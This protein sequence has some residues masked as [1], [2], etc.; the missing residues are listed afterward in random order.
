MSAVTEMVTAPGP[1][2]GKHI[3][4]PLGG[5]L[6]T[7]GYVEDEWFVSGAAQS[8]EADLPRPPDGRW[9]ARPSAAAPFRTR[10][11]VR[12][13]LDPA[14]FNG[15]VLVEWLNVSGGLDSD[16]E[17][18]VMHRHITREGFAWVGV[19]A[20]K[21]GI[22]GGGGFFDGLGLKQLDPLRYRT[23][24]HPGDAFSYDIFTQVGRAVRAGLVLAPL[25]PE[26][27]LALGESQS[28]AFLV[29]YI[30]GI[31]HSAQ[32]FDGYLVH[33][34][35][36][37]GAG[38]TGFGIPIGASEEA[39]AAARREVDS[40]PEIIRCDARTPVL[41][42]QSETDV[43]TL[44]S[45]ASRQEDGPH[46]RLWE[47]AGAA[48]ADTY[49][50]LA[51]F[52]NNG[53]LSPARLAELLTPIREVHGTS[54]ERPMNSGPQQHYVAHAA[55][56]AL[57]AWVRDGQPP[58]SAPR[59]EVAESGGGFVLDPHG[60]ARGGLRTPWVDVPVAKLSGVPQRE[61]HGMAFLLGSTEAFTRGQLDS[62]YPGGVATYLE[63]FRL[64]LT[65]CVAA[66][67]LLEADVAEIEG[68]AAANYEL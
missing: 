67:F 49:T 9:A 8:Y 17:W 47:I 58:P 7:A 68:V 18:G 15:T 56:S 46:M 5:D 26:R 61:G 41:V 31:D 13:P 53:L 39:V 59:L 30:N 44:G 20:Q 48:H 52:Q 11:L 6:T 28:A 23:L 63:R 42:M 10:I 37:A 64:A 34:R 21:I 51:S 2:P 45:V 36:A 14:R 35:G 66:G 32:V 19:S 12:R 40:H 29:T 22:E 27:V 3:S 16:P 33:G 4:A 24:D 65:E 50:L 55:L 62:L 43:I 57:A 38:L 25:Q 60:N 1:E 54:L